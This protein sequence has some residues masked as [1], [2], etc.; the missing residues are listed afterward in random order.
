M[1][2]RQYRYKADGAGAPVHFG[3]IAQNISSCLAKGG[4]HV[5]DYAL[6]ENKALTEGG[7]D[8]WAVYYQEAFALEAA[9]QRRRADKAEER[10][11][12]LERRLDALE[13]AFVAAGA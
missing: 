2:W 8:E 4:V 11:A 3:V 6:V 10:I 5:A 12:A 1:D 13:A 7:K 9:Y